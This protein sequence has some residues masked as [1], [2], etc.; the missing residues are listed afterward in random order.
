MFP[1]IE[2]LNPTFLFQEAFVRFFSAA[3]LSLKEDIDSTR[4]IF[5]NKPAILSHLLDRKYRIILQRH[6]KGRP[7]LTGRG[8]TGAEP[9]NLTQ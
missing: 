3:P 1:F 8:T 5:D 6:E 4:A 2:W 9:V 7:V